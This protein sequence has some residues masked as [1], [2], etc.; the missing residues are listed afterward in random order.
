MTT[1]ENGNAMKSPN[2]ERTKRNPN[3]IVVICMKI[4]IGIKQ[5]F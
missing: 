4:L 1:T 3:E 5:I 2:I